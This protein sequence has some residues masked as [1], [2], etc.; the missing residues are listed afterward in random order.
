MRCDA[1]M[2]QVAC[3]NNTGVTAKHHRVEVADHRTRGLRLLRLNDDGTGV[4]VAGR[5][6]ATPTGST[7][8]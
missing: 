4:E 1:V 7:S 2:L 8:T 6:L 5:W 3:G